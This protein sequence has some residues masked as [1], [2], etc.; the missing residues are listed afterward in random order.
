MSKLYVGFGN[1]SNNK[2]DILKMKNEK[3]IEENSKMCS[4]WYDE[5][6]EDGKRRANE[7][8]QKKIEELKTQFGNS[9]FTGE[10][11]I[12]IID[13]IF[14]QNTKPPKKIKDGGYFYGTAR[15]TQ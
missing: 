8:L 11:I 4:N 7:E 13:K 12:K 1:I 10:Q 14:T 6:I 15:E 9:H 2:K 5:G 3:T